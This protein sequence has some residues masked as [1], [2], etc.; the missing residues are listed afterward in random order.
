ME[1]KHLLSVDLT[2]D[3][4]NDTLDDTPFTTARVSPEIQKRSK[5]AAQTAV[6]A[7]LKGMKLPMVV[8]GYV[9]VGLGFAV[10]SSFIGALP[11]AG[12]STALRNAWWLLLIGIALGA[13]GGILLLAHRRIM[14]RNEEPTAE[15]TSAD[16]TWEDISR[17]VEMELGTPDE[18]QTTA[19]EVLPFEY[20][21]K[22]DGSVKE[23]LNEG[24]YAN[25]PV[26]AWKEGDTLCLTDYDCV[27]KIPLSAFEG[28]YTVHEKYK[29]SVWYK[30]EECTEGPYAAFGIKEDGDCNYR[31][32]TYYRVMIR[33]GEE[34]FEM[35]VPCYDFAALCGLIDLPCL[36]S[37]GREQGIV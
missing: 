4:E 20:K 6:K 21:R 3:K 7:F 10:L 8:T 17:L 13:A 27:I 23:H 14:K 36:D 22:A 29:V 11:E 24:C 35:R 28:Y 33:N 18:E 19:V 37:D 26:Y 31:L 5:E 1:A 25:T 32:S 2:E 9:L 12:L 30:D 34:L 15:E 16:S